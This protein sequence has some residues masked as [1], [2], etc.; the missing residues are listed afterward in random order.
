MSAL[1][2][3]IETFEEEPVEE[4]QPP[5]DAKKLR[6]QKRI[7]RY[8]FLLPV[9]IFIAFLAW[10]FTT[11]YIPSESMLPTLKPGDHIVTIRSWLAY[12]GGRIPS[13]GDIVVFALPSN[14]PSFDEIGPLNEKIRISEESQNQ[15]EIPPGSLRRVK[16]DI[17]IKRV[18]GLPGETIQIKGRDIYIN[19]KKLEQHYFGVVGKPD[20]FAYYSF[21]VDEPLTLKEDEIFVLG[22]NI[23]NSEDGRFWGPLKRRNVVGKFMGVLWNDGGQA[24]AAETGGSVNTAAHP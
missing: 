18:A 16:G 22:D 10:G 21:A 1:P 24:A 14:L 11:N 12:P 19:G 15:L 8:K 2:K 17:L 6:D 5:V 7:D 13:R 20:P 3:R 23:S 4:M 9:L